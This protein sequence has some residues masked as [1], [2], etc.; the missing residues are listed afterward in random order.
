M[1]A[2]CHGNQ[3]ALYINNTDV[4]NAM[5]DKQDNAD[6]FSSE[7]GSVERRVPVDDCMKTFDSAS[8][9]LTLVQRLVEIRPVI[10]L[11]YQGGRRVF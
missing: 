4:T 2:S 1:V 7:V 5:F 11:G 3:W 9:T 10:S 6:D 8:G